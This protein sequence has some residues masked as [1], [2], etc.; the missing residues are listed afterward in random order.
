MRVK[1]FNYKKIM[2]YVLIGVLFSALLYDFVYADTGDD[3]R[4][5]VGNAR[6]SDS[7]LNQEIAEVV[8]NYTD[9]ALYN[10]TAE[11]INKNQLDLY[12]DD[13]ERVLT[14]ANITKAEDD[15]INSFIKNRPTKEVFENKAKYENLLL[16]VDK[17]EKLGYKIQIGYLDNIWES[18][19]EFALSI[20]NSQKSNMDIGVVGSGMLSPVGDRWKLYSPFGT[21]KDL[22]TNTKKEFHSGIDFLCKHEQ[23]VNS[24][25]NGIVT[26]VKSTKDM[27]NIVTIQHGTSVKTVY[28]RLGKVVVKAGD[29]VEQYQ[30]IG[31]VSGNRLHYEVYLDSIIINPLLI[32]GKYG[33]DQYSK[34][35]QDN[36]SKI[37]TVLDLSGVKSAFKEEKA[38]DY[39]FYNTIEKEYNKEYEDVE[40]ENRIELPD[41]F[42]RPNPGILQID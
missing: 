24:Q 8:E 39:G 38:Y 1:E 25:W 17:F 35:V 5:L 41:D 32:F 27:G 30:K 22:A 33:V 4:D 31:T 36:P 23:N 21:R 29:T 3:L 13:T 28:A 16:D 7:S 40:G 12:K 37:V 10:M 11:K 42:K 9:I 26:S 19:F 18:D 2:A 34:W 14:L 6:M 20:R 15:Y